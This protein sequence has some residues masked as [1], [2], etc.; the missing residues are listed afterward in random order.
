MPE[1]V[2]DFDIVPAHPLSAE[3]K[4]HNDGL[5]PVLREQAAVVHRHGARC[6]GQ[7]FNPG[8]SQHTDNFQPAIA[9]SAVQDEFRHHM[10]H[11]LTAGEIADLIEAF[12]L[13]GGRVMEAG[14]DGIE[15]HAAHGYL[16]NQFL[17]PLTNRR[18]DAYGGS[19]ENR[20]RFLLEVIGAL[21][22]H[23]A[24]DFPIG[25][26]INGSDGV[27]GGLTV[28][29]MCAVA[30]RLAAAGVVYL[31]VSGGNYTGLRQG[32]RL[33][34]VAPS[35]TPPGP[36]VDAAA[37]IRL[38]VDVPV[39][40]AGRMIDLSAAERLVA[41]G[42]VDMVGMTRALIADPAIV[43]KARAGGLEEVNRC[44]AC[45]ECHDG[46]PVA[47]AVNAAAGREDELELFSAQPP[48]TVLIVGGGPAGMECAR[49]AALRGH[50]VE[51]V[52]ERDVLGGMLV[53]AGRDPDRE[54]LLTY[55][56]YLRRRVEELPI[57]L[58]LGRR[59]GVE[60]IVARGADV[61]VLATGAQVVAT[62]PGADLEHVRTAEQVLDDGTSLGE[63]IAVIGG[64]DDHL[65]PLTVASLL[66]GRG[67]HVLLLSELVQ[68]GEG[69]EPAT[70]FELLKR[71]LQRG[72]ELQPMTGLRE[73]RRGEIVVHNTLTREHRVQSGIDAVVI[74]GYRQPR[75]EL[76][77][78]LRERV[79]DLRLIGDC[80]SPRRLVHATLEGA[81]L[82]STV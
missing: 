75:A 21:R 57:T 38:T 63:T 70:R 22:A 9:P 15:V 33:A 71:L 31:N 64:L 68:M 23:T 19:P 10:P 44:I 36:N 29:D 56:A 61:V 2:G 8:L 79:A 62:V 47:C 66:A 16:F 17:S 49:V 59:L 53:T 82:G 48:R 32:V 52:E 80:L 28:E 37:A 73:I 7:V 35:S 24:A 26:R 3:G 11:V 42:R 58:S 43:R 46:R 14:L 20:L 13:A 54:E 40:V 55:A 69:I 41:E 39:I 4:A 72:V 78:L 74:A 50:H 45:N 77:D 6:V 60:E 51:I 25:V 34:Y 18:T 67:H 81:R 12:G 65:V 76:A 5:I 1:Y 27:D 30:V